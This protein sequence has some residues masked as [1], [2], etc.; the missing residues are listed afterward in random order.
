M[1]N[2]TQ[3]KLYE[4]KIDEDIESYVSA[5]A[6]VK[7]PAIET[8]FMAFEQH[9]KENTRLYFKAEKD[10][11]ELIGACMIPDILIPRKDEDGNWYD[12]TFSAEDIRT[13][14]QLFFKQNLNHSFNL[15]HDKNVEAKGT[16]IFQS[17][18]VD[19]EKGILP[20]LG[21]EELPCGTWIIGIKIEDLQLWND[22]L[23]GS[24]KGFSVEGIFM[25]LEKVS[26]V[27]EALSHMKDIDYKRT[28][29]TSRDKVQLQWEI[30]SLKNKII[31]DIVNR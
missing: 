21:M 19:R 24:F 25:L 7:D 3:V 6:L 17:Y 15:N 27:E 30:N 22:I 28:N 10:K 18:I 5:I 13:A 1:S 23:C 31:K 11:Q 26:G 12:V 14:S 16:F 20:P 4:I 9:R 2:K 29:K 8:N